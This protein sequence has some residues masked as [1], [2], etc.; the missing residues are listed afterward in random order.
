MKIFLTFLLL[1]ASQLSQ[2]F[3]CSNYLVRTGITLKTVETYCG[4]PSIIKYCKVQAYMVRTNLSTTPIDSNEYDHIKV[5]YN[6]GSSTFMQELTFNKK[7]ILTGIKQLGYGTP[8]TPDID[9]C[10]NL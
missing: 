4:K 2:A 8:T 1:L 3:Y 9:I 7:E 10:S 6:F 5:L